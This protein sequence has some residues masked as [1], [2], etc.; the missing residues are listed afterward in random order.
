MDG[1]PYI[2]DL[3][4]RPLAEAVKMAEEAGWQVEIVKAEPYFHRDSLVWRDENAYVI[5]QSVKPDHILTLI[6][7]CQFE[8]RCTVNGS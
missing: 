1:T 4:A 6:V 8:G 5:K 2:P 7:G 3:L